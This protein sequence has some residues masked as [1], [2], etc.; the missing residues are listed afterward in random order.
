MVAGVHAKAV[1]TVW[2]GGG[3]NPVYKSHGISTIISNHIKSRK[4]WG[5]QLRYSSN[6]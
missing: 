2:D 3:C 4:K 5:F 6:W 1:S